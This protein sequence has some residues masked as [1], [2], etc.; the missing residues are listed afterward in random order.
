MSKF[1][2]RYEPEARGTRYELTNEGREALDALRESLYPRN[3]PA[4]VLC[5]ESLEANARGEWLGGNNPAPLA[6]EGSCCDR[7]ELT[8]VL[9]ARLSL[10]YPPS[11]NAAVLKAF[12]NLRAT[13]AT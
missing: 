4:C 11:H 5:G 8:R 6:D 1:N 12:D 10:M 9:P 7:C 2:V 13:D 3:A